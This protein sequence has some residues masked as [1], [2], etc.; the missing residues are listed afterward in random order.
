MIKPLF[1]S[2][3]LA[4]VASPAFAQNAT[5][6]ALL[7]QT[8]L[9]LQDEKPQNL[10]QYA[11]KVLLVVNTASFCG[12]TPQYEGLEAL[13][14]KYA[15]Q[16]FAVLGFPSNDFSQEPG[17]NAKIADF[18]SNTYGVKFPMFAK[19]AILGKDAHPFYQALA[20]ASGGQVP[21]WNFGK[22]L[23]DRSGKTVSFFGTKTTPQDKALVSAIEKAIAAK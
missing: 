11:G 14:A 23:I 7:Q 21:S 6:P 16:G 4:A 13:H 1:M 8:A 17:D 12:F 18:C 10:C 19:T 20:Q 15:A 3:L 2:L 5:C 22:Y 9:R